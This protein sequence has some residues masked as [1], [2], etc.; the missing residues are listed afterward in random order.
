[1]NGVDGV[2]SAVGGLTQ[3]AQH[4][5]GTVPQIVA[6][7][8]TGG[9]TVTQTVRPDPMTEAEQQAYQQCLT[10][11]GVTIQAPQAQGT[12]DQPGQGP[13]RGGGGGRGGGAFQSCLPERLRE[14]RATFTSPLRT[15]QQ[16]VNPPATDMTTTSYTAAG[17]DPA[18]PKAGL[19]L[20]GR[21][22]REAHADR[23]HRRRLLPAGSRTWQASRAG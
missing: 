8:R 15:I 13:S 20:H 6:S 16:V 14:F 1:V 18:Q 22:P 17:I 19:D 5:T 10:D 2:A 11:A 21:R 3:S 7:I 9:E 4:Q 23:Q 12:P